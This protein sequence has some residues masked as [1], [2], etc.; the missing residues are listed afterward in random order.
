MTKPSTFDKHLK[1]QRTRGVVFPRR[2]PSLVNVSERQQASVRD[3][4]NSMEQTEKECI[5]PLLRREV[6]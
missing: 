2:P 5:S 1:A 3:G 4:H 6:F